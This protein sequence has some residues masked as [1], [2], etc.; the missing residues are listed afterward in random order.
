MRRFTY[1]V[2]A[3][4]AAAIV[5]T[6]F[7]LSP[8]LKLVWNVSA[9]APIGLYILREPVGLEVTDLV[10]VRLPETWQSF[11]VERGYIGN[12]TPLLKRIVGLPGQMVCR[13]DSLITVDEVTI[14]HTREADHVGRALP[15]WH[16]CQTI[17]QHEIFLMNWQVDD[18]LD[19]RYFG[20]L[21]ASSIIGLARPLW[22]DEAGDGQFEW[23]A[24]TQ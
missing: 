13:L 21:P 4:V 8:P 24:P 9:S 15:T 7:F 2:V 11:A 1:V 6:T 20:P 12:G 16:G 14:G 23:M 10:A 22:T 17:D 3:F 5:G 19:G 18:S